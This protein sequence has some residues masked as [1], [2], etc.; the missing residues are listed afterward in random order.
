ME[1]CHGYPNLTKCK[2]EAVV[3]CSKCNRP[4]VCGTCED[5][6]CKL[7][8]MVICDYCGVACANCT[9]KCVQCRKPCVDCGE[10]FCNDDDDIACVLD[11]CASCKKLICGGCQNWCVH[12]NC[13]CKAC[14]DNANVEKCPCIHD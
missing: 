13:L 8:H 2:N 4:T 5:S 9:L 10:M 7:C 14:H 12:D 1:T 3:K 6:K 11:E